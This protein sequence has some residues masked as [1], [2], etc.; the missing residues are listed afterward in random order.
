MNIFSLE[1]RKRIISHQKQAV[2]A[3]KVRSKTQD[4]S[5]MNLD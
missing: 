4:I 3:G 5:K 2:L 1:I